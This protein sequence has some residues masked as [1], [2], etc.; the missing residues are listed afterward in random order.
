MMRL[1]PDEISWSLSS[2]HTVSF[3]FAFWTRQLSLSRVA[4][5]TC[6]IIGGSLRLKSNKRV[7]FDHSQTDKI[8]ITFDIELDSRL[9]L[10]NI[11]LPNAHIIALIVQLG[12]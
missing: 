12:A 4:W 2:R 8:Y 1:S 9:R 5:L 3:G 10:A 11:V 7:L 6:R